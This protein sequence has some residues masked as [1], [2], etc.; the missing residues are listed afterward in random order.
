MWFHSAF[1]FLRPVDYY[2]GN[3]AQLHE[4]RSRKLAAARHPRREKNSRLPQPTLPWESVE[5]VA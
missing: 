5:T 2:R 1:D 3:P 4:A